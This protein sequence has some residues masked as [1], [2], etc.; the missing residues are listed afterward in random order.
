MLL[1]QS[2]IWYNKR[3]KVRSFECVVLTVCRRR[4]GGGGRDR[5]IAAGPLLGRRHVAQGATR[6]RGRGTSVAEPAGASEKKQTNKRGKKGSRTLLAHTCKLPVCLSAL[7]TRILSH[8]LS[9]KI[10]MMSHFSASAPLT[11]S[12]TEEP[13]LHTCTP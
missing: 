1:S 8:Q 12:P 2:V 3:S 7:L 4:E 10:I 9:K 5:A 6:A 13:P 11:S